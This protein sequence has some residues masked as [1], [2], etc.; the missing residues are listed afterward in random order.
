MVHKIIIYFNQIS[1]YL[2]VAYVNDINYILSWRS[3]GLNDVKTESIK[4]KNYLFNLRTDNYDMSKIR[5]KFNGS[6]L[7]RFAPTILHGDI[8]NFYIVYEIISD[9]SSINYP[10][11]ENCLFG[12]VKLTKNADVDKY[13]YSGYGIG[14]DRNT[15]FSVG[16]EIG[17]N[18]IIFGVDMSSS[19]KIDGRRKDILI[20]GKGPTQRLENTL[21]AEKVYSINF[22][23]KN[24][25]FC[26]SLYYN[27]A[28]SYLFVNG[29]EIIKFKSKI[30]K[31]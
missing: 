23:K 19:T 12:S 11:L 27:G 4:T 8:V 14:F 28:N 25:T 9:H 30:Q 3:R 6:F 1:K 17:K 5:I 18:V 7:N 29:T 24:T 31:F 22:T 10:T 26:L 20:L 13:V 21:S 2:K 16:D 15:S